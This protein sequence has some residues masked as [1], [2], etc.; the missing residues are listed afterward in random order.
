MT[1]ADYILEK[2]RLATDLPKCIASIVGEYFFDNQPVMVAKPIETKIDI[3]TFNSTTGN[4]EMTKNGI[5]DASARYGKLKLLNMV[6]S[7]LYQIYIAFKENLYDYLEIVFSRFLLGFD[8]VSESYIGYGMHILALDRTFDDLECIKTQ[9]IY[10]HYNVTIKRNYQIT[11]NTMVYFP[12]HIM[13]P[14]WCL[15]KYTS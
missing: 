7:Q 10:L 4:K 9:E 14:A 2:I 13:V 6:G 5:E 3:S 1:F 8:M 12:H 15:R 11:E